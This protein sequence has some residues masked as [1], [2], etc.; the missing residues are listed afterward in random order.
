MLAGVE[1]RAFWAQFESL[2]K[3]PWPSH[4]EEAVIDILALLTLIALFIAQRI[5]KAQ[6]QSAPAPP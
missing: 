4:H 5:P 6:V 2:T 3:I 1:L